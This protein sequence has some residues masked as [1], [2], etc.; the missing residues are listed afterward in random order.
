VKL[1]DHSPKGSYTCTLI[2]K[3]LEQHPQQEKK[4]LKNLRKHGERRP[5]K[6]RPRLDKLRRAIADAGFPA[7]ELEAVAT[8]VIERAR[9]YRGAVDS[10]GTRPRRAEKI[11]SL[12][13]VIDRGKPFHEALTC[14]APSIRLVLMMDG[15]KL[16]KPDA[17]SI[18]LAR[19]IKH[20]ISCAENE[21][22]LV[23]RD[24]GG[25]RPETAHAEFALG[26]AI[27]WRMYFQQSGIT[28]RGVEGTFQ[29]PLLDFAEAVLKLE[30]AIH[31][32]G[33]AFISKAV[34]GKCLHRHRERAGEIAR[35][36]AS[37][38]ANPDQSLGG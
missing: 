9:W 29:G 8:E 33:A 18:R 37:R 5:E 17:D 7:D 28:K 2:E 13:A 3:H 38:V 1:K 16:R 25:R 36:I 27:I 6:L 10:K 35:D 15:H 26:L 11:A 32:H 14:L 24:V 31:K 12:T 30:G 21:L 4:R 22:R 23:P 34:L 19:D 20:F